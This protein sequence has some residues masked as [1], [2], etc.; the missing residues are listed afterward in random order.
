LITDTQSY[1]RA[2]P[3]GT[4]LVGTPGRANATY[5]LYDPGSGHVQKHAVDFGAD[6][7]DLGAG[8]DWEPGWS[9]LLLVPTDGGAVLIGYDAASG[10]AE[11]VAVDLDGAPVRAPERVAGSP[12]WTHLVPIPTDDAWYSVAYDTESGHYRFGPALLDDAADGEFVVGVWDPGYT[13]LQPVPIGE[14]AGILKY[15]AATG[16]AEVEQL[17]GSAEALGTTWAADL[18]EGIDTV[19]CF[20][21]DAGS[22]VLLYRAEL[23]QVATAWLTLNGGLAFS[24]H[25]STPWREDLSQILPLWDASAPH[26]LTYS[27][28]T[29]VAELRTVLPLEEFPTVLK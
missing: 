3:T 17:T 27:A 19:L 20:A 13:A 16:R 6:R 25:E 12:D 8:W 14:E 26:A 2:L 4:V 23:G 21:A 10:L 29:G 15:N 28:A 18:G 7:Y 1:P 9:L 22:L 11:H 24:G 5:F